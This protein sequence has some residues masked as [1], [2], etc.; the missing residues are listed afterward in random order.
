MAN[1]RT[2]LSVA[3]VGTGA[4]TMAAVA[5]LNI[6][7][8]YGLL[9]WG[10]GTLGGLLPDVDAD[11]SKSLRIV[12]NVLT[13]FLFCFL[14]AGF[15]HLDV[16]PL[17]ILTLTSLVCLRLVILPLIKR[18]TVHRGN[19]HSILT[20][21]AS[22]LVTTDLCYHFFR[23]PAQISWLTGLCLGLGFLIH[24]ILDEIW[25]IN[26]EGLTLK[27]S[28]GSALKPFQACT[29][30]W[31]SAIAALTATLFWMAPPLNDLRYALRPLLK[32]IYG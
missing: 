32:I 25:A 5:G 20:A 31:T 6:S 17:L 13:V 21:T 19:W 11:N 29:P 27:K 23:L 8:V 10:A 22:T 1:F 15:N 16:K 18:I 14:M 3:A 7:P 24:L 28:F 30:W 26:L 9:L 12:A 4:V 2:H